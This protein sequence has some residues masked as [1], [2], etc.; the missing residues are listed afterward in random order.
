MLAST[1]YFYIGTP[2]SFN[3][4]IIADLALFF[5]NLRFVNNRLRYDSYNNYLKKSTL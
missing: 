2:D 5:N 3:L 4:S 1:F